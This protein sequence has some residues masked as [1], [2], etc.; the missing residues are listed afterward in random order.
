MKRSYVGLRQFG[1]LLSK[2]LLIAICQ[3]PFTNCRIDYWWLSTNLV[4]RNRQLEI[5][6][7]Q[8]LSTPTYSR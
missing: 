1:I 4:D 2:E 3:L 5:G 8:F 6:I 7:C